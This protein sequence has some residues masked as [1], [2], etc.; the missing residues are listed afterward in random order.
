MNEW[1]AVFIGGG[2]GSISRYAVS[3]WLGVTEGGFP[4][5]TLTA[6]LLSCL[7]LGLAWGYFT[8][9]VEVPPT[10]K[11]LLL[12]G[13]CGGFSTFSTFSMETLKMFQTGNYLMAVGYIALS[14][15]LC[16][17]VIVLSLR[18]FGGE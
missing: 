18:V 1:L 4:I 11:L 14:I 13:F 9:H 3:R 2:I 5:G 8:R 7:V 12:V 6:N 16:I 15:L 17:L 10:I